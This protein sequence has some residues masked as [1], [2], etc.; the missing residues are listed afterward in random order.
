MT[1]EQQ[2][3]AL[4]EEIRRAGRLVCCSRWMTGC[5]AATLLLPLAVRAIDTAFTVIRHVVIGIACGPPGGNSRVYGSQV[6]HPSLA[7][8]WS[9]SV[10]AV[11]LLAAAMGWLVALGYRRSRLKPLRLVIAT[12]PFQDRAAALVPL[13]RERLRDTRKLVA[14]LLREIGIHTEITPAAAPDARGY[15]ASPAVR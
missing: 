12:V 9:G 2:I 4:R 1:D 5:A 7:F 6:V 13:S 3:A 11:L 8:I 14:P 15:E 10:G